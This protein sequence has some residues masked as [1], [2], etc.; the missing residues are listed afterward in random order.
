MTNEFTTKAQW[1]ADMMQADG[2]KPEQLTPEL[3]L[4]YMAAIGKKIVKM[5]STYL[6]NPNSP[7][8]FKETVLAI[9]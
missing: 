6:T 5:Q 4:A 8:L 9:L 3:A 1:V 2:V 7:R